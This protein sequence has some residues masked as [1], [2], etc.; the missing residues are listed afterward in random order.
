MHVIVICTIWITGTEYSVIS[1]VLFKIKK[2]NN[3][4]SFPLSRNDKHGTKNT[5]ETVQWKKPRKWN[6]IKD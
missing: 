1:S 2:K 5:F 4:S 3:N 6:V